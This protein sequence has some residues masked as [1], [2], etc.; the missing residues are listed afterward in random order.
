MFEGCSSLEYINLIKASE[1]Q[2]LNS[3]NIFKGTPE[4]LVI[5]LNQEK[6]PN[7]TLY[8]NEKK[9][10]KMDCTNDWHLNKM[11][12]IDEIENCNLGCS[13]NFESKIYEKNNICYKDCFCKS[14]KD[15]FYPKENEKEI[16]E[17]FFKCYKEPEGY[18]LG[19]DK[20]NISFIYKLCYSTCKTCKSEGNNIHHNC[21]TCKDDFPFVMLNNQN[22]NV[23]CYNNC[24]YYYYKD[25]QNIYYCTEN[26][27]CP[28][29]YNKLIEH[30]SEC[31]KDC[32]DDDKYKYEFRNICYDICPSNSRKSSENEFLCEPICDG[33]KPYKLINTNE[34]VS[35]CNNQQIKT[36]TCIL[37]YKFGVDLNEKSDKIINE[38]ERKIEEIKFQDKLLYNVEMSFT[39]GDYDTTN[40]EQGNDDII[41]YNKM[42]I[43]LTTLENQKNSLNNNIT[44]IDLGECESKLREAYKIS[45]QSKLF[46]KKIDMK[47]DDLKIPKVEFNVYC[48]LNGTNLVKLDLSY[49]EDTKIDLSVPIEIT[50][51]LD[52][53][54]TSSDYF[55]SIC[56]TTTSDGGTDMPL[57]DRKIEYIKD[58]KAVCQDDCQFF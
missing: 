26:L 54:N 38:E 25:D 44:R 21:N 6:T 48:K 32:K 3:K 18:Y 40:L 12:L 46:M 14:C 20:L 15:G 13:G 51:S 27:V 58:N 22:N 53:L 57:S 10:Y 11:K 33:D 8:L 2:N 1:N 30:K 45:N 56:H 4:N 52:K 34:C 35:I 5:C 9:C 39:S 55:S 42:T 28:T 41:Q 7:F 19:K 43:T 23:N 37:E 16:N 47:Q 24:P 50:E 29:G 36:G 17:S 31:I 49:C